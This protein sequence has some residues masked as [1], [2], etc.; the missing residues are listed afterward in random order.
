M[1]DKNSDKIV[2]ILPTYNE[3][4]NISPIIRDIVSVLPEAN[5][6]VVDDN[7]PD[8][9]ARVVKKL[10]PQ[11]TNLSILER[12]S[13]TGLGDAYKDAIKRAIADKDVGTIITMDA[14]GSH[15]PKYLKDFLRYIENYD[16][17]IGSRYVPEGGIENWE[18]WRR[19]LSKFG[20]LYT[21]ILT[22]MKIN[23]ITA[24]FMC[25]KRKLLERVNFNEINSTGY[26]YLLEFKFY[27]V[28]KLGAKA[29]EIP[30]IFKER[31]RDDSKIS[32][33][34]IFEG[35]KAPLRIFIKRLFSK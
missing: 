27:C 29:K 20:N 12:S 28:N 10:I 18:L 30:I 5:I 8:G 32:N 24:G 11:Y 34:I 15:Q 9:T 22:G 13:K 17:V 26:A 4:N 14:D 33:R 31:G 6:L 7:S 23:D 3:R 19:L 1:N 35:I 2:I 21:K 25:I 16:L